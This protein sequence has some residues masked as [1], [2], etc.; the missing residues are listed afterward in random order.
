MLVNDPSFSACAAAGRRNT[1]VR[2]PRSALAGSISGASP[3]RRRLDLD[4]VAHHQ[5]VELRQR[6]A[7]QLGVRRADGRVL[8]HDEVALDLAVGHAQRASRRSSG[9]RRCAAGSRSSSR[10]PP[11][12][13]RPTTPSAATSGSRDVCPSSRSAGR[14]ARRTSRGRRRARRAASADSRAGCCRASGC[15][16][17]PGSTR[18][19]AGPGCRRRAGRCCPAAAGGSPRRGCSA[20]R[21]CAAS[22]RPRST[23]RRGPLAARVGAQRLGHLEE[24]LA[25]DAADLLDHLRRV[26]GEVPLQDL[27][28]AARVLQRESIAA[29]RR[30]RAPRLRRRGPARPTLPC[31]RWPAAGARP[32]RPRT[33]VDVS[34]WLFSASQP[35]NSP[36][37]SSVSRKSSRDDRGA[38]VYCDTYSRN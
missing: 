19:R 10:C 11:W 31:S 35:R 27:E 29:A 7:V 33:P 15:R 6:L 9:R 32:R 21:R 20:R 23:M 28:D 26:A 38:F 37:R 4:Q 25:R 8:A 22:S 34:Y 36:S 16:S 5:P 3:E 30:A 17:S 24:A 1:S 13:R 14:S 12:P 2:C 18:G